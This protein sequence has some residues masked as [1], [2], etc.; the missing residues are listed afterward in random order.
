MSLADARADW[1]PTLRFWWILCAPSIQHDRSRYPGVWGDWE[2]L[3]GVIA[4]IDQSSGV[5]MDYGVAHV[6][7]IT[8]DSISEGLDR[9]RLDEEL[10]SGVIPAWPTVEAVPASPGPDGSAR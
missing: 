4:A 8:R 5:A 7:L 10:R 1:G 9:L 2:R 6:A 3:A